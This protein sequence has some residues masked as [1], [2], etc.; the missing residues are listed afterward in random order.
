MDTINASIN[1]GI[2]QIGNLAVVPLLLLLII[3]A[4]HFYR[5]R[6]KRGYYSLSVGAIFL[7]FSMVVSTVSLVNMEERFRDLLVHISLILSLTG[8]SILL[9]GIVQLH[10]H[11]PKRLR[12]I[13]LFGNVVWLFVGW[14]PLLVAGIAVAVL[15]GTLSFFIER[16]MG[17]SSS[18]VVVML[19]VVS[20]GY[21]AYGL[22]RV[23]WSLLP[24]VA[25]Y[26]Y[27]VSVVVAVSMALLVVVYRVSDVLE[28][29]YQ[30]SIT[31]ALT[32]LYNRKYFFTFIQ[33]YIERGVGISVIF[34]D[35]D[36]FKKL[37]DVHG[38]EAGDDALRL[39]ASIMKEESNGI[40]IAGRYGGEELVMVITKEDVDVELLAER[41]RLQI[42]SESPV[43]ASIGFSKWVSGLNVKVFV[44]RADQAMYHSKSTGKNK[45]TGY[46]A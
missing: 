1:M 21:L 16:W 22:Q 7:S 36:N 15:Y 13:L 26:V 41:V 27:I 40:G 9:L 42:E 31:D 5:Q 17:Y 39:V 18:F 28:M 30:S 43:T 6:K 34:V 44:D 23:D 46:V 3:V 8:W 4:I 2:S 14:L 32:G 10:R 11:I 33:K 45:V 38:H 25:G 35:L 29:S 19:R 20:I 12:L 24:N 37:N